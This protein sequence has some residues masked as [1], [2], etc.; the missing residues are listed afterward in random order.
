M[1]ARQSSRRSPRA[2]GAAPR[3]ARPAWTGAA[4]LQGSCR[5]RRRSPA[6]C[7]QA[8]SPGHA[9]RVS[10]GELRHAR[11]AGADFWIW[12]PSRPARS[13]TERIPA[14]ERCP[15]DPKQVGQGRPACV[16]SERQLREPPNLSVEV[17]SGDNQGPQLVER[18]HSS[19]RQACSWRSSRSARLSRGSG[20]RSAA[21][22]PYCLATRLTTTAAPSAV[23]LGLRP[24]SPNSYRRSL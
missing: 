8:G 21:S 16:L 17:P 5:S 20:R 10:P 23:A 12:P 6:R 15:G 24:N 14:V 1:S 7:G 22:M 2:G 13:V 11:W 19:H 3:C 4:T 9:C 18:T